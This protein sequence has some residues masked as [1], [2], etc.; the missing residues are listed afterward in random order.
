MSNK[1]PLNPLKRAPRF[2]NINLKELIVHR[3]SYNIS[4]NLAALIGFLLGILISVIHLILSILADNHPVDFSSLNAQI[5]R[6][7]FWIEL[8]IVTLLCMSTV[9]TLGI[10]LNTSI[11][12]KDKELMRMKENGEI[13]PLTQLYNRRRILKELHK[14][15]ELFRSYPELNTIGVVFLDIDHFK[16]INDTYSHGAGDEVLRKIANLL[17]NECRPYDFIGRWGGEEFIIISPQASTER[18]LRF[19]QRL[20]HKVENM[21]IQFE[22][23]TIPVTTSF[24]LSI[25]TNIHEAPESIIQRAD[26]LLYKAKEN[27]RNQI[28]YVNAENE[29]CYTAEIPMTHKTSDRFNQR[30]SILFENT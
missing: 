17:E 6:F 25:S 13:D 10:Y 8:V 22:T 2:F 4:E 18:T 27:G 1:P 19:A 23:H 16:H 24:G 5:S 26:D 12:Y 28:A 20:R 15:Y 29:I 7:Y 3:E 14:S 30:Q 9:G 11:R 21:L